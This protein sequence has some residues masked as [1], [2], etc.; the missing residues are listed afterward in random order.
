MGGTLGSP[1]SLDAWALRETMS[2]FLEALTMHREEID[3][4]NVFPVPDGDT[5]SNMLLT[6][7][8]VDEALRELDG[9]PLSEVAE[10]VAR[11]ALSGARGNSGTILS[12]A[13]RGLCLRLATAEEATGVDL[14][15]ALGEAAKE[16]RSAVANP[17]EGTM[18]SVLR[19]AAA[20]ARAAALAGEHPSAVAEVA[21]VT[22]KDALAR[23]PDDLAPLKA[24]GVVDAGGMGIVLLLDAL[25][26]VLAE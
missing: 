2:R 3:S 26:S 15:E 25:A 16:A 10:T 11:S 6:Q 22:A 1:R 21:L 20:G 12:Q 17:V 7:R 4:L 9:P 24:H 23:T 13:L 8:A 5:G 18:L 14:A 19:Y